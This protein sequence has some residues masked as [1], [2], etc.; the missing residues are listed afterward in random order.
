[1]AWLRFTH[2]HHGLTGCAQVEPTD[3]GAVA[4]AL[5]TLLTD[6]NLWYAPSG[7]VCSRACSAVHDVCCPDARLPL[8]CR[9]TCRNNG[10]E[11][12]H[13]YSWEAHCKRY[14]AVLDE[15]VEHPAP[16]ERRSGEQPGAIM[17]V[18]VE[19]MPAPAPQ[20]MLVV[21]MCTRDAR[22]GAKILRRALDAV[23]SHGSRLETLA[24]VVASALPVSETLDILDKAGVPQSA[25]HA[26]VAD[27]GGGMLTR[28]AGEQHLAASEPWQ[29]HISF[30]WQR[31]VVLRAVLQ[32]T[33]GA[34]DLSPLSMGATASP[35]LLRFS[36]A[37][38]ATAIPALHVVMRRLRRRGVRVTL[39]YSAGAW[40][41]RALPL[42]CVLAAFQFVVAS[43]S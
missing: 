25:L 7:V 17:G 13:E 29:K 23:A 42:R 21:A 16:H 3:S 22:E 2:E 9:E 36:L 39:H 34:V 27:A 26:V 20:R 19:L 1:V 38:G 35:H 11:H 5:V 4:D 28:T 31:A 37:P 14:V 43:A 24:V 30:A 18:P 12:I 41:L 33:S 15:I 10:L 32:V 6:R 8:V 40:E